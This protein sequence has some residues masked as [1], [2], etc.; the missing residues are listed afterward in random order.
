MCATTR[1]EAPAKCDLTA[2]LPNELLLDIL[3]HLDNVSLGLTGAVC[4]RLLELFRRVPGSSFLKCERTFS[5]QGA[6]GLPHH[7]S[8]AW[9][10]DGEHF[11]YVANAN[12]YATAFVVDTCN[13]DQ[14]SAFR[15]PSE[16]YAHGLAWSAGL[17]PCAAVVGNAETYVTWKV[18]WARLDEIDLLFGGPRGFHTIALSA[19]ADAPPCF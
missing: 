8:A 19:P 2:R 13:G 1:P 6:P 5:T 12:G 10:P 7:L 9:L 18:A 3:G 4:R 16:L 15:L 11:A 14:H 17:A